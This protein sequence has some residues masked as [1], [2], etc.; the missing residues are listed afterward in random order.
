MSLLRPRSV[1]GALLL[2]GLSAFTWSPARALPPRPSEPVPDPGRGVTNADDTTATALNPATLAFLPGPELRWNAVWTGSPATVPGRGT[3]FAGGL[4][5]GPFATA[6]RLDLLYPPAGVGAPLDGS[7]QWLRWAVAYGGEQASVGTTLAASFSSTAEL[8]RLVSLTTGVTLRPFPALSASLVAR[9]WN[10]PV[11][12]GGLSLQRSWV[13]GL[14]G[15]PFGSRLLESAWDLD[16]FEHSLTLGGHG[17]VGFDLPRVGRIR[18]DVTMLPPPD[19]RFVATAGVEV[20]VERLQLAA[21]AVFGNAVPGGGAGFYAGAAYRTFRE[22]GLRLPAKVVRLRLDETPGVRGNTRLLRRLWRLADDPEV[23]GVVLDLHADPAGSLAHAEEVAD[24]VRLL[25]AHHKKV[26]CHL[27]DAGGKSLFV[28]SQADR[29]AMNPAGGLRFA[30]ISSGYYYLGG[31]LKKL[32][33]RAD[34]VRI[35]AHKLAAEQ[36]TIDRGSDVSRL[37]HQEPRRRALEDLPPRHRRRPRRSPRPS[38][39]AASPP[40]P[41]SPTR[42]A[43]PS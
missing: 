5:I 8:D 4:P 10:E 42:R 17:M 23:E 41:S 15:R 11:S 37:D 39:S 30:G 32:G 13:L 33:V 16:F 24:A 36:L 29:I 21:G 14:G 20:N 35:G 9:D 26:M 12:R 7:S 6:L 19:R 22:P 3:S 28:C 18:A 27:E 1:I 43:R 25:R 40:A 2:A 34:F 38:S 31:L